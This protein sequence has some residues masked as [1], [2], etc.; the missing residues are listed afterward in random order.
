MLEIVRA[1]KING[2]S[3]ATSDLQINRLIQMGRSEKAIR[4]QI[5]EALDATDKEIDKVFSDT[6]YEQYYG[7]SRAYKT[8]GVQQIPFEKNQELQTLIDSVAAQ[9]MNTFRNITAS[10]GFAIQNPA[11]GKMNYTPTMQ[12]YQDTLSDAVM[13]IASGAYSYDRALSRAVNTMTNSGLRW[14]DYDSGVHFRVNVAARNA[15]MTG[16]RQVQGKINEQVAKELGTDFYEVS[17][18]VGARQTHQIWQGRVY[19][20]RELE[21]VCGLGSVTGLHGAS[22]YHDYTAFIPGVSVRTYTDDQLEQMISDENAVKVYNGKSYTTY[23]ALQEQRRR[24]T[25]MR[26]TR[27]DIKLLK[28]GD[29]SKDSITLVQAKYHGQMQNYKDF[30]RAMKLPEQMQRVYLD[31]L[32]RVSGGNRYKQFPSE[33]IKNASKDV[34]QYERY[35]KVLGKDIGTLANF[36]QIKYNDSEKWS[37]V[38]LDYQRR[39]ELIKHPELRLPNAKNA[40]IPEEKFT[41]YLFGGTNADGIPKGENFRNRLGYDISNW[42]NLQEEI[43]QKAPVYPALSKGNVG[44]GDKYEQKMVLMGLKGTPAN[45]VVGW[46]IKPDGAPSMTSAYI[47]EV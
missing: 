22:C 6:V 11:T 42:E 32:G 34:K 44:F 7:Y 45:V 14:I 41:K 9:T 28:E 15:I 8:I 2:F 26:K 43:Q 20:Y 37:F 12:F 16:F 18:H 29:A 40:M 38:Q 19:T 23:E 17:Y 31:G 46:I 33:M 30:S 47:K 27:Q 21:S 3:T 10:T 24:E 39:T 4:E 35:K 5:R 25:V 36:G 1:I 13:D